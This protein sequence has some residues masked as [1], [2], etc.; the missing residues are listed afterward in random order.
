MQSAHKS[1]HKVL[2]DPGKERGEEE[3]FE[4][5]RLLLKWEEWIRWGGQVPASVGV[6]AF[7]L[8]WVK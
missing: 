6:R 5:V 7:L 8:S 2:C 3:V 4:E 1:G